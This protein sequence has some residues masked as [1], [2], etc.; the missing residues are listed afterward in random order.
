MS[1]INSN[2]GLSEG[3]AVSYALHEHAAVEVRVHVNSFVV[4]LDL[5][6]FKAN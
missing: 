3:S 2:I 5:E 4:M 6:R 1:K